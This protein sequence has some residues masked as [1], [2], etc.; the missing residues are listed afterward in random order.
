MHEFQ[1]VQEKNITNRTYKLQTL[2]YLNF[3]S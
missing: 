2:F 3:E 1:S